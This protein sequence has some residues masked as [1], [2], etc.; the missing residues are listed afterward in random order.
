[1]KLNNNNNKCGIKKKNVSFLKISND[2]GA[3]LVADAGF[4]PIGMRTLNKSATNLKFYY[5]MG[6]RATDAET[7]AVVKY[8]YWGICFV[9][10]DL[11]SLDLFLGGLLP[12]RTPKVDYLA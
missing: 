12:A 10:Q 2:F 1:M 4:V 3:D 6:F 7:D 11:V 8:L 9:I 5:K